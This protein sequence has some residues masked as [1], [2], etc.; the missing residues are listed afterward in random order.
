MDRE[1]NV[2]IIVLLVIV[3]VILAVQ[4]I[5]MAQSSA[6]SSVGTISA[7][8]SGSQ[9]TQTTSNPAQTI[10]TQTNPAAGWLTYTDSKNGFSF[11]YPA[12]FG[13]NVWRP[14]Q[15]PPLVTNVSAGQNPTSIG[16]PNLASES[17]NA[18]VPTLGKTASGISYNLYLGSDI[19]AGQLYS[20]YCY[21]I[22]LAQA[23]G[24][25]V[26]DFVIQSHSACG[27]GTC[28]A[29]CGTQ[30]ETECLNLNRKLAIETPIQQM[31]ST[32]VTTI[33][34]KTQTQ[35]PVQMPAM[36]ATTKTVTLAD[37]QTNVTIHVGDTFLLQL[38]DTYDWTAMVVDPT[39][40]ARVQNI[41][42]IRGAQGIY[43]AL[44]TGGTDVTAV[45][46]PVCRN[47]TPPCGAPSAAFN[48][49]VM[50]R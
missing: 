48:V 45:G 44:K 41:A 23:G 26:I 31:V 21:V 46:D 49:H 38:G 8:A 34:A 29:Y 22:P 5:L 39:I 4:I 2:L 35:A 24:S 20:D 15:W 36:P 10:P 32:F 12:A 42:V 1:L 30:Y 43:K 18:P 33:P 11:K 28:G 16:C 3:I 47:S 19:G 27:F 7:P 9:G 13:A 14:T 50:V 25:A 37:N 17:G 6:P 40:V